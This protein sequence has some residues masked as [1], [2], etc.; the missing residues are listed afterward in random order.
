MNKF[1]EKLSKLS[2]DSL[3]KLRSNG[4][5]LLNEAHIAIEE[6]LEQR[7]VSFP[8]RPERPIY[9]EP[10]RIEQPEKKS[11]LLNIALLAAALIAWISAQLLAQTWIGLAIAAGSILY[12]APSWFRQITKGPSNE[13][14]RKKAESE[15]TTEIMKCA[16]RSDIKRLQQ[17]VEH[18]GDVNAQNVSGMTALMFAAKNNQ[19]EAAEYLL[20][21]G[22]RA[23]IKTLEGVTASELAKASG[24][25]RVAKL[26]H[27]HQQHITNQNQ[28]LTL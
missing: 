21:V 19:L 23:D 17:L 6:I 25:T 28:R 24:A 16:A 4:H 27:D 1:Q 11:V 20:S 15:S 18:G 5:G 12:F 22:A 2:S 8:P 14:K 7:K 13:E 26:I 10:E 3:L 9:L